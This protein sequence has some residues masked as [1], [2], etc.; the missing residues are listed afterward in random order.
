MAITGPFDNTNWVLNG[1]AFV[2]AG[3]AFLVNGLNNIAQ[4]VYYHNS[5]RITS[6]FL[7]VNFVLTGTESGFMF[8]LQQSGINAIGGPGKGLGGAGM[9]GFGVELDIFNDGA[10]CG[11]QFS[12]EIGPDTLQ[13]NACGAP[14]PIES[15]SAT[16]NLNNGAS[17]QLTIQWNP[18]SLSVSIDG[19][20]IF[21]SS[22]ALSGFP[23]NQFWFI[24]FTASSSLTGTETLQLSNP[25][26][27][28][29]QTPC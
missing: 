4:S 24:G 23:T 19:V 3:S 21:T 7:S 20:P 12:Q 29:A 16:T 11:D 10:P 8:V 27:I 26:I 18:P 28:F 22:T 17:R 14:T 2:S 15:P 13:A 5:V 25:T 1:G 9:T 6:F